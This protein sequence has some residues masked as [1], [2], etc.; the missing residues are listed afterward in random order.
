MPMY[1]DAFLSSQNAVIQPFPLLLADEYR[2]GVTT[3]DT[4]WY[5]RESEQYGTEAIR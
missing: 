3:M 1:G 5:R 2:S 4:I